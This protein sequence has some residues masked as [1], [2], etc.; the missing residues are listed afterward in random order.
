MLTI[1]GSRQSSLCDGVSRRGF[2]KIGAFGTSLCLADLMREMLSGQT[3][4]R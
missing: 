1:W 2:L 4:T 3:E